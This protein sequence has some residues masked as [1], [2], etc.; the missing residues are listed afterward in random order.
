MRTMGQ[1]S[2]LE[3]VSKEI[4]RLKIQ[5][6]EIVAEASG[7]TLEEVN[8]SVSRDFWLSAQESVDYGFVDRVVTTRQ[9][10]E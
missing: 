6:N 4:D 5:Y 10:F 2:D 8:E 7:K 1:A 3:I 9:E